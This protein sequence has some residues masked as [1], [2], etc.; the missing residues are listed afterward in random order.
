MN[1]ITRM[2]VPGV[3][4]A[5][6]SMQSTITQGAFLEEIV[7]TAQKRQESA[8]DVG[9]SITAFSAEQLRKLGYSSSEDVVAQTPG[10]SFD[11]GNFSIRGVTQTDFANHQETPNAV[12]FDGVYV[13]DT[14]SVI[15]QTFDLERIEVL[16]GPQGTLFGR[17]ATGGLVHYLSK[18]PTEEFDAYIEGRV[19]SYDTYRVEGAFGGSI[20]DM[21]QVRVSFLS[22]DRDGFVKNRTGQDF[23]DADEVGG[24][25]QLYFAPTES[26]DA[27]LSI[28]AGESDNNDGWYVHGTAATGAD[29]LAFAIPGPDA[30]GFEDSENP[31][32]VS[33]NV[34]GFREY[35]NHSTSFT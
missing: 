13:S 24:R 16:K 12:Y 9:L 26:F 31:H 14:N 3:L 23:D 6:F 30:L 17:N 4:V 22:N 28:R 5:V 1:L 15:F 25:L 34:P 35:E 10:V 18:K 21:L 20:T 8:Q 32:K 27:L 11:F 2:A 19:G 33:H 7:V 29:G